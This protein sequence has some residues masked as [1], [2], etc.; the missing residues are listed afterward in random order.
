MNLLEIL[1]L[2][3]NLATIWRHLHLLQIWLP[4]GTTCI[5]SKFGHQMAPLESLA[6]PHCRGMSYWYYQL[7]LSLYLHQLDSHQL[8]LQKVYSLTQWERSE[9]IDRTPGTPGSDKNFVITGCPRISRHQFHIWNFSPS[10]EM[11]LGLTIFRYQGI[12][13]QPKSTLVVQHWSFE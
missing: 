3:K 7:V 10:F 12:F 6:L 4:D 8:S 1:A 13:L 11:A 9:P 2:V 5:S